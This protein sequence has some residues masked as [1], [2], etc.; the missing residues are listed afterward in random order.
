MATL[1]HSLHRSWSH[2]TTTSY[3][4]TRGAK[5][6]FK[7]LTTKVV[8]ELS[9]D[10]YDRRTENQGAKSD[11][12]EEFVAETPTRGEVR[13]RGLTVTLVT[14]QPVPTPRPGQP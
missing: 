10:E 4:L 8:A 7:A 13:V 14:H 12:E 5:I 3:P 2:T 1:T 6:N 9:A 11:Q